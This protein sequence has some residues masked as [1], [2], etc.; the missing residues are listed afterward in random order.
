MN[1]CMYVCM[2]VHECNVCSIMHTKVLHSYYVHDIQ[3]MSY[4]V[5]QY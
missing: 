3:Y 1:E 4:Y 5:S 2:N